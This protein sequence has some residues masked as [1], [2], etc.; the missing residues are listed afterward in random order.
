MSHQ[1]LELL[2]TPRVAKETRGATKPPKKANYIEPSTQKKQTHAR[3][4]EMSSKAHRERAPGASWAKLDA[5]T[6]QGEGD[7]F[8][9]AFC[10]SE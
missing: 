3:A 2:V 4:D 10:N 1:A 6:L 9:R 5:N 8:N 7:T